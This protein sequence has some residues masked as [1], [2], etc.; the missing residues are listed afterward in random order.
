MSTAIRFIVV[1]AAATAMIP[2]GGSAT[3]AGDPS[4]AG[5]I[6]DAGGQPAAGVPLKVTGP[7]QT[8]VVTDGNGVW[9]LYGLP[10]GTYQVIPFADLSSQGAMFTV[11]NN[12]AGPQSVAP[13][14]LP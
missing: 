11:P 14:R 6:V 10:P 2:V 4:A 5:Q 9:T 1:V 12:A 7:I 13:L 8:Y 3:F